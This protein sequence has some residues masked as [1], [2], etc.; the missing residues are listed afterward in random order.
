VQDKRIQTS[1]YRPD[2]TRMQL[3]ARAPD[4]AAGQTWAVGIYKARN[5]KTCALVGQLRGSQI[6]EI[7]AGVFHAYGEGTTGECGGAR[8]GDFLRRSDRTVVYGIAAPGAKQ[9]TVTVDGRPQD[10]PVGSH[11]GFV[12]VYKGRIQPTHIDYGG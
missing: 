3:D 6:G 10:A 5:G 8:S 4:A 2:G 7:K 12:L 9:V 11:G 1:V